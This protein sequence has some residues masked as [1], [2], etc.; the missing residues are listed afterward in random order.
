MEKFQDCF[1]FLI[2]LTEFLISENL[3]DVERRYDNSRRSSRSK[4]G[5]DVFSLLS[6]V[7]QTWSSLC[8]KPLNSCAAFVWP[9]TFRQIEKKRFA[10]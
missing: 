5:P 9:T 8:R 10:E 3:I 6:D 7:K 1:F 4:T 2:L